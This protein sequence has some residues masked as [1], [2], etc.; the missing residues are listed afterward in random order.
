MKVYAS[1]SGGK[2]SLAALIT[3]ME[4]GGQCDGA[5]YCRIM[6]DDETSAEVPEHEEW[7]H[8]KCFP[9][10]ER[11]YGIKTQIVQ[12]K[13]TY[14]D[15]FYKQYEKG[16]KVGKIWGFPFLRGAWCN[17]RLKVRPIQAHI[18]TLGEFT[19]IVGI[20]ADE[21]KRI[22][23]K[24]VAGKILPLVECGIT[25][26]QAFDVCRSRGLL[27]PGYNGGRERLG[28]WFSITSASEN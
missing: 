11:E 4:R 28:C 12:G 21:T 27:S 13:Y 15:C 17:T 7:L 1:I 18:K 16:G 23:R 20:A 25:E 22:E 8:S 19:E 3:H 5:I 9:L 2:D 26:A 14:T 24:T 6:F 10:L